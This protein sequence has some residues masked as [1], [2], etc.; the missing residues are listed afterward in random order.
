[1]LTL[2]GIVAA[3]LAFWISFLSTPVVARMAKRFRMIDVPGRHKAH[4]R[5]VP[6]LGGCAIFLGV[7]APALLTVSLATC[8]ASGHE[9][10]W[11]P[12]EALRHL[13]GAARRAPAALGILLGAMV[14]H[15]V[16]L[17]DDRRSLGPWLKLIAEVVVATGVVV[18]CGVRVLTAVGGAVS[19]LASILWLVTITNAFNFLDN[20]DGLSAGIAA[21]CA[22][23]LLGAAA[24]MGQVFVSGALCLLLGAL[25]G[26]LPHN[27]PPARIFMGDAGSLV[28]G[29]LLAVLSCLT[30]YTRPGQTFYLYGIFVPLVLMAVPLYDMVSVIT[31]RL[32]E[33]RN[34]MV[35][36]RRHFS[37][38]LLRRGMSVRTAV[39]T[40][41]LCTAT[42]ALSA[43]LLPHVADVTGA[44]LVFVQTLAVLLMV[45]L[46]ESSDSR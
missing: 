8:W 12:K 43:T 29:F 44:V 2:A 10:S 17:I 27:L 19:I 35:G 31:L 15:V 23:A 46:L 30:T 22:A 41:Y 16:G 20:M 32:R 9:P 18:F 37:H 33:R 14:L 7:L 4:G 11:L 28:I 40:I 13:P 3:A 1:M 25:L 21:I 42:T 26:F 36:D 34:P 6:L 24:S 45:A 5:S 38:R 39:L